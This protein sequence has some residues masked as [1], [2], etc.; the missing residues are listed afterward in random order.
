MKALWRAGEQ[1]LP[2]PDTSRLTPA[3]E[4]QVRKG[5]ADEAAAIEPPL[6]PVFTAFG[7]AEGETASR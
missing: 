3:R 1:D 6:S 2:D 4:A 7:A 5:V